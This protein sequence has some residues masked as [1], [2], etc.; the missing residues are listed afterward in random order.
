MFNE[1][2]DQINSFTYAG[3]NS[4]DFGLIVESTRNIHGCP[5]PVIETINIPGRGNLILNTKPDLLDNEEFEDYEKTYICYL[6]PEEERSMDDVA[7]AIFAWLF[8]GVAY[9]RLEDTYEPNYYRSAYIAEQLTI[10]DIAK[11]LLGKIE[12]TFTCKAF[13]MSKAGERTITLFTPG[14]IYNTEGFTAKPYIKLYGSGDITLYINNRSH[15]FKNIEEFLEIDSEILTAY[16][17]NTLQNNKVISPIFPKLTA[18]ANNITWTGN[19]TKVEIL[20]RWCSL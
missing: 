4:L 1:Y 10:T 12:I 15:V 20:P 9:K 5:T 6:C 8:G 3:A 16:K 14:T 11:Q 19:V 18:G 7:K 13:K 2:R 17:E